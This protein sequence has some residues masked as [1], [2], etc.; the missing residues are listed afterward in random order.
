MT[1]FTKCLFYICSALKDFH[2]IAFIH[3]HLYFIPILF[4]PAKSSVARNVLE[5]YRNV[6]N[7]LL[8]KHGWNIFII[9]I[10]VRQN[11]TKI[12]YFF[13]C[14]FFPPKF[15]P[16]LL[17]P[18]HQIGSS[19]SKTR[20]WRITS[21]GSSSW[22][23]RSTTTTR[24]SWPPSTSTASRDRFYETPFRPKS[25]QTVLNLSLTLKMSSKISWENVLNANLHNC[26]L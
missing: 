4:C 3:L 9:L 25:F 11:G 16:T 24:T 14:V 15:M 10:K 19:L 13:D 18:V 7:T 1:C 12:M 26:R 5:N 23:A 21:T 8:G 2:K 20:R 6:K 22:Q 17:K